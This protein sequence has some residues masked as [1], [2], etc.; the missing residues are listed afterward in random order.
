MTHKC[1]YPF[2]AGCIM[3]D[4]IQMDDWSTPQLVSE[5]DRRIAGLH[6]G[7]EFDLLYD[8][9]V[10]WPRGYPEMD[11]WFLLG[12]IPSFEM[13]DDWGYPHG[14]ETPSHVNLFQAI[15]SNRP[16]L[17]FPMTLAEAGDK[18]LPT[19]H[20]ISYMNARKHHSG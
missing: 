4:P 18:D 7:L 15:P 20:H 9:G 6:G 14:L 17:Q 1:G 12:K 2:I 16:S 3:E 5:N 8:W 10:P 13:D 11:G 19:Q